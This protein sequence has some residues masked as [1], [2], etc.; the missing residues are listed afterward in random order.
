MNTRRET[1]ENDYIESN[2]KQISR[3]GDLS[4]RQIDCLKKGVKK[5]KLT[6]PL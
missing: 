4:P 5:E 6:I 2:I 1:G 3:A